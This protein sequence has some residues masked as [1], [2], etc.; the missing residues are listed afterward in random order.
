MREENPMNASSK[1]FLILLVILKSA[2]LLSC[3]ILQ[4]G[5][6]EY[7]TRIF[8][9]DLRTTATASITYLQHAGWTINKDDRQ[10]GIIETNYTSSRELAI[11]LLSSQPFQV[12]L[13]LKN[14]SAE[15]TKIVAEIVA[16]HEHPAPWKIK[17]M[18]MDG[19]MVR[20]ERK[21]IQAYEKVFAGIT[22]YLELAQGETQK[23]K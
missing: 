14:I 21:G 9:K 22:K 16:E 5:D 7:R 11:I 15:G 17:Q 2:L 3:A 4:G 23:K 10:M 13:W 19:R 1:L 6:V 18:V 12:R 8:S 20:Y